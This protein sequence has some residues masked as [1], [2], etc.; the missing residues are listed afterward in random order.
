MPKNHTILEVSTEYDA[1]RQRHLLSFTYDVTP[2]PNRDLEEYLNTL[3]VETAPLDSRHRTSFTREAESVVAAQSILKELVSRKFL[4]P[5]LAQYAD[6]CLSRP[7]NQVRRDYDRTA[8]PPRNDLVFEFDP[9]MRESE[10]LKALLYAQGLVAT[11]SNENPGRMQFSVSREDIKYTQTLVKDLRDQELI[12][13]QIARQALDALSYAITKIIV[14]RDSTHFHYQ[15]DAYG[16]HVIASAIATHNGRK[17]NDP[18]AWIDT[19]MDGTGP[20]GRSFCVKDRNLAIRWLNLFESEALIHPERA[21]SLRTQLGVKD[22]SA[23]SLA[24]VRATKIGLQ[25]GEGSDA[26]TL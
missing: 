8:I 13:P 14:K 22:L 23:N 4:E 17:A 21:E 16:A 7:I 10:N 1:E 18:T 26:R 19:S 15:S 3:K 25:G 11:E 6:F 20:T 5:G 12:L 9:R 2:P 24:E